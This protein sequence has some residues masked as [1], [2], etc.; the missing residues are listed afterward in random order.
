MTTTE[1]DAPPEEP[2]KESPAGEAAGGPGGGVPPAPPALEGP[3]RARNEP[4]WTRAILPLALPFLAALAMAVWVINLSRAFLVGGKEGALVI[5]MIVT[6]T[7]MAG[8]SLMSA[9][10][11]MRTGT[12]V[13][14]V[15]AL[16]M[17]IVTA[18]IITLG[19]SEDEEAG[20]VGFQEP[21]GEPVAE[22]DVTA[23]PGTKFDSTEYALSP[24][25]I[26][27][28]VYTGEP[29]HTLAVEGAKFAGFLLKSSPADK[30]KVELDPGEYQ[31]YCT[32]TGHRAAGM[33]ATVTVE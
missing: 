14:L 4:L 30:G 3:S 17:V 8:A 29:G 7:I 11:R 19:P 32:V 33:E 23:G 20:P 25:G 21:K 26:I 27:E 12:S 2:G 13:M 9:A 10:S 18:G 22:L 24:G 5:V 15:A 28:I 16:L 6:L 1:T 31:I